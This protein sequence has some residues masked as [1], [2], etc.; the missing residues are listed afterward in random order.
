MWKQ[1][2]LVAVLVALAACD[3]SSPNPVNGTRDEAEDT[4]EPAPPPPVEPTEPVIPA[5]I[6]GDLEGVTW[7]PGA[8]LADDSDDTLTITGLALDTSPV[9][10]VYERAPSEDVPGFLAYSKQDD[11]LDRIFVALARE[12]SDGSVRGVAAADGGQFDTYFGGVFYERTT[13]L[14]RPTVTDSN[15]LVSYAGEYAAVTNFGDAQQNLA[16]GLQPGDPVEATPRQP[17]T[18]QG[19]VFMNVDFADNTV[20]GVVTDRIYT[21]DGSAVDNG[22]IL[23]PGDLTEEGSFS[24]EVRQSRPASVPVAVGD[25][26]GILGGENASGMAGGLIAEQHLPSAAPDA[27]AAEHGVWVIPRCGVA[28]AP[29]VCSGLGDID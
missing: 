20:N 29:A 7:D 16:A 18:I 5:N 12:A 23:I 3:G 26:A 25:Y 10:G 28:G 13:P 19:R 14:T 24:G 22:L 6:L 11:R 1:A 9:A 4:T 2:S 8:N 27:R 17:R 21:D 15:G